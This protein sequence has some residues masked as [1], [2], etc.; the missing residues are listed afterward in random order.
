MREC[1][2]YLD[3]NMRGEMESEIATYISSAAS[4]L[5]IIPLYSIVVRKGAGEIVQYIW[6]KM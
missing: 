4:V 2:I 6:S 3:Q 1:A 5:L